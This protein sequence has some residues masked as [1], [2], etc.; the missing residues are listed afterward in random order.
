MVTSGSA[1]TTVREKR[2]RKRKNKV[3]HITYRKLLIYQHFIIL[4]Y[5][6]CGT[7]V[8]YHKTFY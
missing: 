6:A 3:E 2:K 5:D 8:F 7:H 1:R 4:N